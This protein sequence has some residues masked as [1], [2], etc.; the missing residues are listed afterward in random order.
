[1]SIH[2]KEKLRNLSRLARREFSVA[3]MSDTKWRKVFKAWAGV[4]ATDTQMIV[5]F[6]DFPELRLN[7]QNL[8]S[9][10]LNTGLGSCVQWNGL[11]SLLSRLGRGRT[12]RLHDR[13]HRTLAPSVR[14]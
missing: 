13:L 12:A 9:T 3:L 11:K 6:L 2:A 14:H 7:V 5:K 4:S 8:T 1:M 10:V